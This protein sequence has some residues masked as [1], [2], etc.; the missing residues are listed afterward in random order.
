M[1]TA[2]V[3][4]PLML[5]LGDEP[6]LVDRAI[7]SAVTAARRADPDVERREAL[8]TALTPMEFSDLV[9]PSLFAEP[10]VV[11]IRQAHESS[12]EIAAAL[13]HYATDPVE[14]VVLVVQ[15]AG[16]AR[17]KALAD[18]L[19]KAG[20]AV[21]TCNK[22]TKPA[23]RIEFVRHEIRS[24]GGTTTP[25]AVAAIVDAIGSDLRELAAAASQLVADTGGMVDES[26]VRR[27]HRGRAEVSGFAVA[28]LAVAG[29]VPGALEAL[30]WAIGV[31][32]APVLVADALADGIRTVAKVSGARP[33]NGYALS[34]ELGMPPWKIDR[35]RTAARHWTEPGLARAMEVVADL[36]GAVKGLA[37]DADYALEK[38]VMDLSRARRLR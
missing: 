18:G 29:D 21:M 9:A 26:A 32:V 15:H 20:A 14:G 5:V 22:L 25:D 2:T 37:V 24:A 35:A 19:R 27:Y 8:A 17:N 31:G 33:G 16:G 34:G 30:R 3:V 6:L 4:D 36:N 12:K 11:V 7:M 23:E 13:G 1:P 38:A 10:R 28:D